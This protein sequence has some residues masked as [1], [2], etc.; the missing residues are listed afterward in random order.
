MT[1]KAL[2]CDYCLSMTDRMVQIPQNPLVVGSVQS[3]ND[4]ACLQAVELPGL[5]DILEIR[6]DGM[7]EHMDAL[8]IE[9]D[10]FKDFPLLFTARCAN[11]GG[12]AELSSDQRAELLM[13]VA[14]R[15]SWI[16]V[17][18]ASYKD[19]EDT[20]H[21]IRSLG[22]GLIL[23][24]HNFTETPEA[25]QLQ[26]LVEQ[27]EGADIIKMAVHHQDVSDLVRCAELLQSNDR[28]MSMMGM[29]QLAPVSRLLYAQH[30]SLLNYGYLGNDATAPGQ[31]PAKLLRDAIAM[32]EPIA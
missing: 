1:N 31:W 20:L 32:L 9:L 26:A 21:Q 30:G 5:C 13:A 12:L 15:A 6:L 28:P 16:D 27:G 4:L 2:V 10:R 25:G 19:M 24:Y 11:E 8:Q 22:V 29:G 23:S 14:Q 18:L 17:E 3:L 7:F